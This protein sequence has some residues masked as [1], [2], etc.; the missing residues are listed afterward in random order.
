MA[1]DS[2]K[3]DF[4]FRSGELSFDKI[5]A[6]GIRLHHHIEL[7]LVSARGFLGPKRKLNKSG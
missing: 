7:S 4:G 6:G 2:R 1:P 5:C 3:N